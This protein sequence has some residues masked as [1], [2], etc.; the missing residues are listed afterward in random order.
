MQPA[1]M[2]EVARYADILA[3]ELRDIIPLGPDGRLG[4][5]TSLVAN[6]HKAGLLVQPW[7][8]RP[9]NHFLA[10]NFQSAAGDA[11][12][13]EAGSIAEIRA[14]LAAGI[15]GFFTDDPALGRAAQS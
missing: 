4:T 1:G 11:A 15:D 3:P 5:P 13:N 2:A 7:T 14:Y 6:A 8:F 9:E 12:R 10:K